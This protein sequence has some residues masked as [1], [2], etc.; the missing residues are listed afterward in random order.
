MHSEIDRVVVIARGRVPAATTMHLH[1][2]LGLGVTEVRRRFDA[3][4]PLIDRELWLN[5]QPRV[6][7]LLHE[8]LDLLGDAGAAV[9]VVPP[10]GAPDETT[11]RPISVLW[12]MIDAAK[13][14]PEPVPPAPNTRVARSLAEA[15]RAALASLPETVWTPARFVHLAACDGDPSPHLSLTVDGGDGGE[16]EVLAR[17]GDD[18]F[19]AA[20]QEWVRATELP[21]DRVDAAQTDATLGA[22]LEEALRFLDIE[23]VFATDGLRAGILLLSTTKDVTGSTGA[24]R[25]LNPFGPLLRDWL[26]SGAE[27]PLLDPASTVAGAVSPDG[28]APPNRVVA[29]LWR[30]SPGLTL[31]DGTTMYAPDEIAERNTTFQVAVYAPGWVL[32]GDDSGGRGYLMRHGP[33]E[34]N[35]ATGRTGAEVFILDLGA[36][37]PDIAAEAEFVTDDLIGWL[38]GRQQHDVASAPD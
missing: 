28:A 23:G 36:L 16:P 11:R 29:E 17:V 27:V 6:E 26:S 12:N 14:P 32:I 20:A 35:P 8:V 9:Y 33:P 18:V 13:Q 25:R 22:T 10:G 19:A 15:A 5:D 7:A 37:T 4:T 1:R 3:G 24:A 34:F 31:D 21:G 2:S 30:Q 38:A